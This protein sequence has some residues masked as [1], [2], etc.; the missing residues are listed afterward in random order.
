MI[1]DIIKGKYQKWVCSCGEHG[2][3]NNSLEAHKEIVQEDPIDS[4]LEDQKTSITLRH[5]AETL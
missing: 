4:L 3:R 2:D 5:L 1:H